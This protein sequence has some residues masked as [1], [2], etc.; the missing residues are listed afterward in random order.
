MRTVK[1]KPLRVIKKTGK[2]TVASY[3]LWRNVLT[4]DYSKFNL[5]LMDIHLNLNKKDFVYNHKGEQ[6]FFYDYNPHDVPV[7]QWSKLFSLEE[8]RLNH[9]QYGILWSNDGHTNYSMR[10]TDCNGVPCFSHYTANYIATHSSNISAFEPLTVETVLLWY[11]WLLWQLNNS[12]IN[13]I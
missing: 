5:T 6:L 9:K 1:F 13:Q 11:G 4:A 3:S 12:K 10:G 8:I 2:V 7:F